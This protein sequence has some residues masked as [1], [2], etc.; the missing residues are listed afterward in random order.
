[1]SNESDDYIYF[2]QNPLVFVKDLERIRNG[3]ADELP[4]AYRA[5][6][7]ALQDQIDDG[8]L[9]ESDI[10][11]I[12]WSGFFGLH[13]DP[14]AHKEIEAEYDVEQGRAALLARIKE[15]KDNGGKDEND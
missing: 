7:L 11:R 6:L 10:A 12:N 13:L 8:T 15:I 5:V 4:S 2:P 3:H 9:T 1:M 14:E